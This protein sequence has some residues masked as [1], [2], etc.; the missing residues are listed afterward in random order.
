MISL[1]QALYDQMATQLA[2]TFHGGFIRIFAGTR[3]A[4]ASHAETGTLLGV[5]SAN[6]V[7]GAGLSFQRAADGIYVPLSVRLAFRGLAAGTAAWFRVVAPADTG[8]ASTTEPRLDGYIGT[9]DEPGDMAW[10][11]THV[12][13]DVI[14]SLDS[15][16]YI[17]HPMGPT[18]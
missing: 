18:P 17:I 14:H 3:P 12:T 10:L 15:F 8:A 1:S 9:F 4:T 7:D 6:A 16:R 11:S 2:E 5:V 13:A